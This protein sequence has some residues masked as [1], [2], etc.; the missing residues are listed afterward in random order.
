MSHHAQD[1]VMDV[2]SD[3]WTSRQ[4]D[5]RHMSFVDDFESLPSSGPVTHAHIIDVSE[6]ANPAK[7]DGKLNLQDAIVTALYNVSPDTL[8]SFLSP[9]VNTIK[10]VFGK[11]DVQLVI[12]RKGLEVL[13]SIST[14]WKTATNCS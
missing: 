12:W 4:S 9:T 1:R 6:Y 8:K 10:A 5:I 14:L 3:H 13:V 7:E 11:R 2:D